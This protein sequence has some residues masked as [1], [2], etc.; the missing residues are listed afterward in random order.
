MNIRS[1]KPYNGIQIKTNM[2]FHTHIPTLHYHM[3]LDN[4]WTPLVGQSANK[5]IWFCIGP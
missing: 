1:L 4:Y 3:V 2:R 5:Q